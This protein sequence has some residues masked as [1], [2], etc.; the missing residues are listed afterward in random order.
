MSVRRYR[1]FL[2]AFAGGI[3]SL[4][5]FL[6]DLPN[7]LTF[8]MN[9]AAS[10]V[11]VLLTFTPKSIKAFL[12]CFAA[13]FA[14]NFI[15]AGLMLAVWIAFK[16]DTMVF[17]NTIVYFNIDVK[18]L[19][20]STVACY[21]ALSIISFFTKKV[22]PQNKIYDITLCNKGR[23]VMTKALLDTGNSLADGF[24]STPVIIANKDVVRKLI[25]Y[26]LNEFFDGNAAFTYSSSDNV[27]IIP[28]NSVG[29]SGVLRAVKIDSITIHNENITVDNVLLAESKTKF[30][31]N[32]YSVL[33]NNDIFNGRENANV[34]RKTKIFAFKD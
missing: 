34:Q 31:N 27:R 22:A 29:S 8:L 3:Y 24:S 15:F 2:G 12:K 19:V 18:I 9:I 11:I 7:V 10:S 20:I 17:N 28:F 30:S 25:D 21:F 13:F 6:P 26:S 5:I 23:T 14:V 4:A 1:L 32:E 33:L 16:P